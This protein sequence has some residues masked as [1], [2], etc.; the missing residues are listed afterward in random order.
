[1][2]QP[3]PFICDNKT[4]YGYCKFTACTDPLRFQQ[5]I[6]VHNQSPFGDHVSSAPIRDE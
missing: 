4:E 6:Q 2:E 5:Q 1:M 3:C